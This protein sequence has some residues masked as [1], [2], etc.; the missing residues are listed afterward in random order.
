MLTCD[1][2]FKNGA[3]FQLSPQIVL[4]LSQNTFQEVKPSYCTENITLRVSS[5]AQFW[6]ESMIFRNLAMKHL[7]MTTHD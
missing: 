3:Y 2:L 1:A 7:L 5:S 6:A 4:A